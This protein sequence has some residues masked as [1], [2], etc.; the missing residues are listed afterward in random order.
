MTPASPAVLDLH[1][2]V[3]VGHPALD[4]RMATAAKAIAVVG[5]SGAGKSTLLR[6]IAGLERRARGFVTV[7]GE[8]WQDDNA[9]VRLP[10]WERRVGWVPQDALLFPHLSVRENLAFS[11]ASTAQEVEATADVLEVA[12]LLERRPRNLSGGER[13]RVAL[14]RALLADPR[15]LLLDEP[16]SALDRP[17]RIQVA[18]LVG[19]L[20][21]DRDTPIVLVSHDEEDAEILAQEHWHLNQGILTPPA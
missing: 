3:P 6:A 17:L 16:F 19:R 14:G 8:A 13:Q 10:V 5:P 21:R 15:I 1:V 12:H 9:K 7:Q 2:Q 18:T 20:T 11:G 4:L